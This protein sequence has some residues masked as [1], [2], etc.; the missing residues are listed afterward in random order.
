MDGLFDI[1]LVIV[2][3]SHFR[4]NH[5]FRNELS[6][7]PPSVRCGNKLLPV[8]GGIR[9]GCEDALM[10]RSVGWCLEDDSRTSIMWALFGHLLLSHP[11]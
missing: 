10:P 7:R 4:L 8:S 5:W 11:D 1:V 3:T 6:M 2:T 9:W